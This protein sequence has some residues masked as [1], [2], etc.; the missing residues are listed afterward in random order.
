MP[1]AASFALSAATILAA[2]VVGVAIG[3]YW[4]CRG[5]QLLQRKRL[6]LNAPASNIH[7]A[8]AGL[9]E[10]SGQ[11]VGPYVICSP[12]KQIDCYHYHSIAWELKQQGKNSE[13]VKVAEERLHVPFYVDDS[14][15]KM[16]VDPRGAELDLTCDLQG[17]YN[18]SALFGPS[19]MPGQ[20]AEF[21]VRHG[22]NP[23][24]HIKVE[25]RCIE[26]HD[27]VFVLGTL[28]QN[29]G[30]DVTVMP[31]WAQ[32]PGKKPISSATI[33]EPELGGTQIIRLSQPDLSVPTVQMTQQQKIAAALVKAGTSNPSAWSAAGIGVKTAPDPAVAKIETLAVEP[34][35]PALDQADLEIPGGF[36]LH[37]PLVLMKGSH[38]P[39]F[40]IS[41]RSHRQL[42]NSLGWKSALMLSGGPALTLTCAYL[43]LIH[44]GKL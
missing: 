17:Q 22:A 33:D 42:A 28:S 13:W 31:S 23:D 34:A 43:L 35:A 12:L 36:D 39:S 10:I 16:L 32:R 9:V 18:R 15:G 26:P 3:V 2:C 8:S 29:P 6:I 25:E 24:R 37:P 1:F 20:I 5:W 21:L 19:E 41:W 40:F 44:F 30:L 11:A 38:E 14:T 4:I 7:E 27:S